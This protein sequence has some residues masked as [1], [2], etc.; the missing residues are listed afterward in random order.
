MTDT[1]P[2]L[3]GHQKLRIYDNLKN[4]IIDKGSFYSHS[5][6]TGEN[7]CDLHPRLSRNNRFISIDTA[8]SGKRE[9]LILENS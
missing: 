8:L 1:Y 3:I 4:Q 2:N 9:M 5:N 7:K 6:F